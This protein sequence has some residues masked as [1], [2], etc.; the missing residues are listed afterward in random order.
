MTRIDLSA[1]APRGS[2]GRLRALVIDDSQDDFDLLLEQLRRGGY[3][4]AARR[5]QTRDALLAAVGDPGWDI[6]FSDWSMPRFTAPEALEILQKE[7]PHLP[8]IIISGVVGEEVAVE[9][10][11]AGARDFLPKDKLT[12]LMPAVQRA[13]REAAAQREHARTEEQLAIS[14]RM[15]TVGL[16]A[17]STAHEINNPLAALIG[18]LD[19]ALR[20]VS[21]P[22]L[23]P[24]GSELQEELRDA[25][26]AAE[27]IRQIV[28]DL[29]ALCRVDAPKREAVDVQR[30]LEASLR[31]ADGHV[32]HRAHLKREYGAVPAVLANEN[33]LGQVFVNLIVN[34]AQSIPE[35]HAD[36]HQIG[37]ATS[38]AEDGQVVVKI[39]D[40]GS[41]IPPDML[42]R[43]FTPFFTTKAAD[44]MGL[45][46][47][48]CHRIVAALGGG[49]DVQSTSGK[50]SVF[51][52]R[53]EPAPGPESR[54]G[55]LLGDR[56]D[57][58]PTPRRGRI[59]IV[60]D[61]PMVSKVV[62]KMLSGHH[63]VV[64]ANAAE[65]ALAKI[66]AGE[67]FDVILSDLI[68]PVM[69]GMDLHAELM[70]V[71]PDQAHR[72]IFLS[73]AVGAS[74]ARAFL[75]EVPNLNL[76]KPFNSATLLAVV[77]DRVS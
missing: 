3:E 59:M 70:R 58:V 71:A 8:L 20:R 73:G 23:V 27:R 7:A 74:K 44:G 68:M 47:A 66:V 65:D 29:R 54:P 17:A 67:R 55:P 49:I 64:E 14:D 63:D 56:S 40:T 42:E 50:G 37:V 1:A 9:A 22:S 33:R 77:G 32:R 38:V 13:L 34:A 11:R 19:L 43:V 10:L 62:R 75:A 36:A 35:G 31:I 30:V 28:G 25:R 6:A 60:D 51:T 5:V 72:M 15:A 18:N 21:H 2:L 24:E 46:L 61:E 45:G 39:S 4:T 26:D 57:D 69:T 53:L 52:V 48:I 16:L 41:G 12:R 76:E